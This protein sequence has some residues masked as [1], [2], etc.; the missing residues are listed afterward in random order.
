VRALVTVCFGLIFAGCLAALSEVPPD[1]CLGGWVVSVQP[2][3]LTLKFNDKITTIHLAP[4]AEIWRRG[5]NLD[6]LQQFV[7]GDEIYTRCI[8]AADGS[9]V[10]SIVAAVEE[11]DA[12]ALEPHH[13]AERTVCIGRLIAI[14]KDSLTL[15]NDEG[16]CTALIP[17]DTEIWRGETFHDTSALR[18]GDDVGIRC[19]VSYPGR[20]LTA[21]TVEANVDKAEGAVVEVLADRIL[22]KEDR[23]PGRTTVLLDGR[24]KFD[25]SREAVQPG[26]T[27]MAIGLHI[28]PHSLRATTL[29]VEGR[30]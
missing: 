5:R 4:G 26:V 9:V 25:P 17:A 8:R 24:T 20:I 13:I 22:V 15:Q 10:A 30:P 21:E 11:G 1:Q 23:V 29:M 6:N 3:S 12:V 7:V 2:N 16:R 28:R 27:V 19:T 14:A 18:L